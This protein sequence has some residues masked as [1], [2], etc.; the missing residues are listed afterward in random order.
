MHLNEILTDISVLSLEIK[1]TYCTFTT[2]VFD[3]LESCAVVSFMP[4]V[5]AFNNIAFREF[6]LRPLFTCQSFLCRQHPL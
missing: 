5:V 1:T 2:I 6:L 3:T 4:V